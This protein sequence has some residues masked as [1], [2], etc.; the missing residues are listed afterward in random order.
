MAHRTVFER[1]LRDLHGRDAV[2]EMVVDEAPRRYTTPREAPRE[3]SVAQS[4]FAGL[5]IIPLLIACFLCIVV[6]LGALG[7]LWIVLVAM[8]HIVAG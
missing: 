5:A 3:F 4:L 2:I 1:G 8:F 6:G 7:L